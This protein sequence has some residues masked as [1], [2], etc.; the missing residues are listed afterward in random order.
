MCPSAENAAERRRSS[1][2]PLHT[3]QHTRTIE[4]SDGY[5]SLFS[6][7]CKDQT[8]KFSEGKKNVILF[9]HSVKLPSV[10]YELVN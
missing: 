1:L 6:S 10:Y 3:N 5:I 2:L 7:Q 4:I 9:H 8:N